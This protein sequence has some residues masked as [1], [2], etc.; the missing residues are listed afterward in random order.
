MHLARQDAADAIGLELRIRSCHHPREATP[1]KTEVRLPAGTFSAQNYNAPR[2]AAAA[3]LGPK[4]ALKAGR[5][6]E[7]NL[8]R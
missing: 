7:E 4:A 2:R 1:G 5:A 3:V 6:F 8:F